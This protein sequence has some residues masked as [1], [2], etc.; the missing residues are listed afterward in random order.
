VVRKDTLA[1]VVTGI[2]GRADRGMTYMEAD[3]ALE[4]RV[5]ENP[6]DRGGLLVVPECE[7]A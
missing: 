5:K 2:A 7:A 4:E 6:A 3:R 1:P